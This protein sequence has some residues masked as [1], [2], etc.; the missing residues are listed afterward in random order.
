MIRVLLFLLFAA[1]LAAGVVWLSDQPA[2]AVTLEWLGWRVE[3][4][5]AVLA[6]LALVLAV[7][8]T[9]VWRV[10]RT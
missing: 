9:I 1:G 6:V 5:A 2:G 3:T 7:A 8:A 10:V 4:S